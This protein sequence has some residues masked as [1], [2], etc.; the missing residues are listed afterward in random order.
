MRICNSYRIAYFEELSKDPK[1][2][3]TLE[4]VGTIQIVAHFGDLLVKYPQNLPDTVGLANMIKHN[5]GLEFKQSD[6]DDH[7]WFLPR[8]GD[9]HMAP[10][11]LISD[12]MTAFSYFFW[13]KKLKYKEHGAEGFVT[14]TAPELENFLTQ[15]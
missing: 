6:T 8:K 13:D 14:I 10:A 1:V 9:E 11:K 5:T 4:Y 15:Y 2:K 7:M 3:K 12:V